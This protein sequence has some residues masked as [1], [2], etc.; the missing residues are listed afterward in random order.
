MGKL[1]ICIQTGNWYDNLYGAEAG[2]DAA[3]AYLKELGFA[4][5]DYNLDHTMRS[6]YVYAG[7]KNDFFDASVEEILE[8]FA[9]VKAASEKHGIAIDLAHGVFPVYCE[10]NPE[11][12]DYLVM[13]T[14][15][16]LA[17]CAYLNCP[18]MVVHP[19]DLKDRTLEWERNLAL[20]R[21]LIPDA[22]KYG[23]KVC[24]E[25]MI[26]FEA[27]HAYRRACASIEEACRYIDTLNGEAGEDIF[28]FCYDVG[29]ANVVG[30]NLYE[31]LK[32]LGKRLTVLHIHEND[33]KRDLHM[34]PFT[35]TDP[36]HVSTLEWEDFLRGLRDI[37]YEGPL[38]FETFASTDKMPAEMVKPLHQLTYAVG[39]YFRKQLTEK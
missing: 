3:F 15:K 20:Y 35:Q 4:G 34:I 33:G 8:R 14:Q 36:A 37:G 12:D 22:K 23:V 21:K 27:G 2:V 10:V 30:N 28:G 29:H 9:G 32:L 5:V 11:L 1:N 39:Q 6:R 25:N 24:L 19:I 38:S 18:A 17:V 16:L 26:T 13:A 31:D 7:T